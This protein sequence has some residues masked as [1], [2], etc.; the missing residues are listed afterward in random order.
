MELTLNTYLDTGVNW[1]RNSVAMSY[2]LDTALMKN[3]VLDLVWKI[4]NIDWNVIATYLGTA[5][6]MVEELISKNIL[7]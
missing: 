6:N 3:N 4:V 7:R 5:E 1:T 2:V